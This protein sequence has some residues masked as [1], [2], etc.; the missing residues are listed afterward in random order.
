AASHWIARQALYGET[1]KR[2]GMDAHEFGV[3]MFKEKLSLHGQPY[4][5]K[6][7]KSAATDLSWRT[8]S[9]ALGKHRFL[10]HKKLRELIAS[11]VV[12]A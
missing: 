4:S 8:V 7:S 6:Q 9:L 11:Q 1:Y 2:R 12:T 3:K 5:A 10:W